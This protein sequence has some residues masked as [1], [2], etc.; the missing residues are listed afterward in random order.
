MNSPPYVQVRPATAVTG[1]APAPRNLRSMQL[2]YVIDNPI[3]CDKIISVKRYFY[4]YYIVKTTNGETCAPSRTKGWQDLKDMGKHLKSLLLFLMICAFAAAVLFPAYNYLIVYPSFK[5]YIVRNTENEA[6]SAA[7]HLSNML[8]SSQGELGPSSLSA[9]VGQQIEELR[10]DFKIMELKFFD[11]AG[12]VVFSTDRNEIGKAH[13]HEEFLEKVAKGMTYSKLVRKGGMTHGG[14][15]VNADV[16]DIYIPLIK[17]GSSLGAFELVY[18]VTPRIEALSSLLR[19]TYLTL[20]IASVALLAVVIMSSIKTRQ[21]YTERREAE[22]LLSRSEERFKVLFEYAPDAYYLNDL[23]GTFVDGNRVAEELTGYGREELIGRNFLKLKLLPPGQVLKA[24]RLLAKSAL[25]HTTGPDEFT[26]VRKD[27][28]RALVEI[29]TY[30]VKVNNRTLMLGIARDVTKRKRA[31]EALSKSEEKFSKVFLTSPDW[32]TITTLAEGRYV[33]VNDAFLDMAGYS[34][35][36]VIGRTAIELGIWV[37]LEERDRTIQRVRQEGQDSDS[38]VMFRMKSGEIRIMLR[39][40]VAIELADEPCSINVSRDITERKKLQ[41][42]L[43]RARKLESVGVLAGGIAHDFNNLLMGIFGNIS[44]AR[45]RV[46]AGGEADQKLQNAES[47]I[48]RAKSLTSQLLTFSEGGSPVRAPEH[49]GELIREA[50]GLSLSGSNVKTSLGLPDD[51]WL[52]RVDR[53]LITQVFLGLLANARES[54]PDGGTVVVSAGNVTLGPENSS[55]LEPGTYVSITVKDEGHGI[56]PEDLRK[57]FDPYFSTK[58]L[59]ARKG[60]G[61]GLTICYSII[62]NHNGLITAKSE[63]GRGAEFTVLLPAAQSAGP[64]ETTREDSMQKQDL[65]GRETVL[66]M[67]DEEMIRDVTGEMLTELGYEVELAADGTEALLKYEERLRDDRAFDA[68]I[69]DLTVRGGMGGEEAIKRLREL[70]PDVKAIVSS[71]Y[72][73]N[74]L[75]TDYKAYGFSGV[76]SKPYNVPELAATLRKVISGVRA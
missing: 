20:S 67:D 23:S 3:S 15:K 48:K 28:S 1:E 61:L 58:E 52:A 65:E 10:E 73:E 55:Q 38:E 30:P 50:C 40:S 41:E 22:Q 66:V 13:G 51:L 54:M 7:R 62:M 8:T 68:V 60:M 27:G 56:G 16:V 49:L 57:V 64:E 76:V 4:R 18:D 39:S 19:R 31:E 59:G 72:S 63:P 6:T 45:A 35:D 26:I 12:T 5:R 11:P 34:R 71:G 33:D 37:D 17:G 21:A 75:M 25:G 70:D 74:L 29:I 9:D 36:E 47:A 2:R 14:V 44:L 53:D 24:A 46:P 69:V 43:L 42:D 32:V